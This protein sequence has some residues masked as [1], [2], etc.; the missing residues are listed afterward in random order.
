M[1]I[2]MSC[3]SRL[4]L[5]LTARRLIVSDIANAIYL[6]GTG[7]ALP[8]PVWLRIEIQSLLNVSVAGTIGPAT[9]GASPAPL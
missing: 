3:N 5:D 2:V 8:T 1:L 4:W 7:I 6:I 9:E